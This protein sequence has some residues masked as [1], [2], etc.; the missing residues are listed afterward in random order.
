QHI[1]CSFELKEGHIPM[2]QNQRKMMPHRK[3]T[4]YLESSEWM[5]VDLYVTNIDW[6]MIQEHYY[7]DDVTYCNGWKFKQ[8]TGLFQQF[9]D[10]WTY[11][12]MNSEGAIKLLA[13]LMLNSLYGKF[14]SNPDV[15][16]KI[17]YLKEDGSTGFMD[18]E[19]E[20]RD[21]VYTPMGVF[22]TSWARY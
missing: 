7:V 19:Q 14:A 17:P 2:I 4:E 5:V 18:A 1:K 12:K 6:E 15:T 8:R 22:I 9:I 20:F 11:V 3:S 16:G 21:P 13:K 10:K